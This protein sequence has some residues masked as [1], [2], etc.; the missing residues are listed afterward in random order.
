[1]A[2]YHVHKQHMKKIQQFNQSET[3]DRPKYKRYCR[4][5]TRTVKVVANWINRLADD[6]SH[7]RLSLDTVIRDNV[8]YALETLSSVYN[9]HYS[10]LATITPIDYNRLL[11]RQHSR[12]LL[13]IT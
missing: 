7:A 2:D 11:Y 12:D 9:Q 8:A 3:V 1:M 4:V 10:A 5:G 6:I 13:S